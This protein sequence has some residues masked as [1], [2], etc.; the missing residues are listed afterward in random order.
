MYIKEIQE[1]ENKF[2][3]ICKESFQIKT[4]KKYS[5]TEKSVNYKEKFY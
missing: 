4:F 3:R 5:M 1:R 2:R